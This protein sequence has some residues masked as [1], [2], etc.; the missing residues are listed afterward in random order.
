MPLQNEDR[1]Q[2]RY[3]TEVERRSFRDIEGAPDVP[4]IYSWYY[5]ISFSRRDVEQLTIILGENDDSLRRQSVARQFLNRNLLDYFREVPY[6]VSITGKLKP[7][8]RGQAAHDQSLSDS[9]VEKLSLAPERFS[10]LNKFL[11][12]AVPIFCTPLYIGVARKSLR[13]RLT[14]H[15]R[16]M[17]RYRESRQSE[18][19]STTTISEGEVGTSL[20][21]DHSFAKEV[22][23]DRGLPLPYLCAYILPL[24][25]GDEEDALIAENILNRINFPIYGR[26]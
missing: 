12:Q 5:E 3:M 7:T 23:F 13:N 10:A 2:K 1:S 8:Y 18:G 6:D 16:L 17:L 11:M 9:I 20:Q 19:R 25:S 4:G 15:K 21:K 24:S 14:T 22:A 26:N